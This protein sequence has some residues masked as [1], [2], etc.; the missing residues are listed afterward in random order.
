MGI[1]EEKVQKMLV[2]ELDSIIVR[3]KELNELFGISSNNFSEEWKT[4]TN[5]SVT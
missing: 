3:E 4:L 5:S 2:S 1:L